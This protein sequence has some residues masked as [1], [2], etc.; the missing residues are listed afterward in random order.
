[1]SLELEIRFEGD[2]PD[3]AEHRLSVARFATALDLLLRALR[4]TAS[5]IITDTVEDLAH[6]KGG[7]T[8][9]REARQLDLQI[10][11]ISAGSLVLNFQVTVTPQPDEPFLHVGDL[12][13]RALSRMLDDIKAESMGKPRNRQVRKYLA[14]LP[15]ELG[16]QTYD[17]R[18][19]GRSLRRVEFGETNLLDVP[20]E[21]LA[22]APED[23]PRLQR[24]IGQISSVGF[25]PD[26]SFVGITYEETTMRLSATIEQ[27]ETALKIRGEN[28]EVAVLVQGE[29][30]KL[31]WL[32]PAKVPLS[33]PDADE[34]IEHIHENWHETLDE[35]SK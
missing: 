33:V 28:V 22:E 10:R 17:L 3:L 24:L 1:M 16:R 21:L 13:D 20:G 32:R 27:V 7:G 25:E 23:P 9:A 35:L 30:K 26:D 31:L 2:S 8:Y 15:K 6:G 5:A 19:D 12:P 4:R 11:T 34:R 14:E 29:D 18:S